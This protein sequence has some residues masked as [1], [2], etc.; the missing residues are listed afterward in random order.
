MTSSHRPP[1]IDEGGFSLIELIVVLGIMATLMALAVPPY[2]GMQRWVQNSATRSDLGSD[3]TAIVAWGIDNNGLVPGSSG[4]DPSPS[5]LNLVGYGWSKSAE[6][7]GYTYSTN[8]A[9]T[10]WCLEMTST[11]GT[12]FRVSQNT[13]ITAGTCAV[14]GTGNY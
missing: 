8:P 4:F 9:G 11:S 13:A 5:A 12:V 3:R 1:A 14:L 2:V 7:T 6:T 10:S